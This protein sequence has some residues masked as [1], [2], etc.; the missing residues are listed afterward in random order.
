M[1]IAAAAALAVIAGCGGS[2]GGGDGGGFT[3]GGTFS[4]RAGFPAVDGGAGTLA[5]CEEAT[6]G[7]A[8]DVENNRQQCVAGGNT[9]AAEPCPLAGAVGGCRETAAAAPGVVLTTWY[10]GDGTATSP[11]SD[12]IRMLCEGLAGVAPAG[13]TVTFVLP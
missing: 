10:Y 5:L 7:T 4:C 3:P 8:Q 2:G 13:L 11:T 12:D 9:F 6:G 1:R